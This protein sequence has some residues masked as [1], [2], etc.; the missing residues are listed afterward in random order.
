[1]KKSVLAMLVVAAMIM[2]VAIPTSVAIGL[3]TSVA[4][5][6]SPLNPS[7]DDEYYSMSDWFSGDG[8]ICVKAYHEDETPFSNNENLA[9]NSMI[10]TFDGSVLFPSFCANYGSIT[11][12]EDRCSYSNHT[13]E[14]LDVKE[15]ILSA[16]N[17]IYDKYHSLDKWQAS[18]ESGMATLD[19]S[20]VT[21][22]ESTKLLAQMAVWMFMNDD[23]SDVNIPDESAYHALNGP[24]GTVEAY[25]LTEAVGDGNIVDIIYFV[26]QDTSCQ[27][28]I[29]PIYKE[30]PP[31]QG[32]IS[33]E[34]MV[35]QTSGTY[36]AATETFTFS[37]YGNIN[38][39]GTPDASTFIA[40][41]MTDANGVAT[42]FGI[43]FVPDTDY[44]V[45]EEMTAGQ[46]TVYKAAQPYVTVTAAEF[47]PEATDAPAPT[48]FKNDLIPGGFK[49][50]N[51]LNGVG[52]ANFTFDV[53]AA[54]DKNGKPVGEPL[55]SVTVG[56]QGKADVS[57][58]MFTPGKKY[59]VFENL[60]ANQ[61]LLYVGEDPYTVVTAS[62]GVFTSYC[63]FFNTK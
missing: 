51:Y 27:P 24:I 1:M 5:T 43:E 63:I 33:V 55:T 36:A 35:Q 16:L 56:K 60:T 30:A 61:K 47:D 8:G 50:A 34:K 15:Y 54:I 32:I 39:D 38:T 46:K 7:Y 9:F 4:A 19:G 59:Y 48:Q 53:Y 23:V 17:F 2:T 20:E 12:G 26:C 58:I 14:I 41:E 45:F 52:T 42:F 6:N 25:A 13:N 62:S 22:Y 40:K 57:G 11:L 10:G 44:Y 28:Q 31:V 49:L 18:D 37:A 3:T 29:V 21:I